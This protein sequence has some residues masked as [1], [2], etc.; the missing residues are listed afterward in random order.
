MH[1]LPTTDRFRLLRASQ[2]F[3]YDRA[4]AIRAVFGRY[5]SHD[6]R[7]I[8]FDIADL[9]AKSS[10]PLVATVEGLLDLGAD[11]VGLLLLRRLPAHERR[12]AV[13]LVLLMAAVVAQARPVPANFRLKWKAIG[14]AM[15]GP[16][17]LTAGESAP[18]LPERVKALAASPR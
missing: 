6:P 17:V 5:P 3:A 16:E 7:H 8:P 10:S 14:P 13:A 15:N 1:T 4:P 12:L 9:S 18:R 11:H 2:Q